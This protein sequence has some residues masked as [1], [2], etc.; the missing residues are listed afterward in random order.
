MTPAAMMPIPTATNPIE[1]TNPKELS[2]AL[3][4]MA[5]EYKNVKTKT[6]SIPKATGPKAFT[7]E[8]S[9]L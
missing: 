2:F 8:R 3:P 4:M 1:F 5:R 6:T 7:T 9:S